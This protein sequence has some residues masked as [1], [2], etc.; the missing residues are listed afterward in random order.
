MS[1]RYARYSH[2]F[3]FLPSLI[4]AFLRKLLG[5]ANE[6]PVVTPEPK[7]EALAVDPLDPLKKQRAWKDHAPVFK[8]RGVSDFAIDDS[9]MPVRPPSRP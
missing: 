8:I 5:R 6:A 4:P 2:L 7:K 3:S 1:L 9:T